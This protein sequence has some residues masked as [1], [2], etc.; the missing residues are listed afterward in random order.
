MKAYLKRKT[1]LAA[2]ASLGI[3]AVYVGVQIVGGATEVP[4]DF[5][6]ARS[7]GALI[8]QNIVKL[9]NESSRDLE[10]INAFDREGNTTEALTL[11]LDVLRR[12]Q[13]IREEAVK[14]SQEVERMTKSL[15]TINNLEARQVAL[16]AISNHLALINRLINYSGSL[17][18]LLDVLRNRFSGQRTN[19]QVN[20]LVVAINAEVTAI[21]NFSSQASQ[22]M[23]R[24]DR[25]V[26]NQ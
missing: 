5:Y 9:S 12:S 10:R 8:A 14:L 24:F 18:E 15:S 22:A 3:I 6:D 13:E 23:A 1:T 20:S 2:L 21:N 17:A 25:I 11:T 4:I 19:V 16:E 7:Q 26:N